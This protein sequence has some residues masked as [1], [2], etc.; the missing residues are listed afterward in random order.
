MLLVIWVLSYHKEPFAASSHTGVRFSL[1][2]SSDQA[3]GLGLW[4]GNQ[5][6]RLIAQVRFSALS[7]L[8]GL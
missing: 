3:A 8:Y 5:I 7:V 6:A 2:A 1:G 4:P